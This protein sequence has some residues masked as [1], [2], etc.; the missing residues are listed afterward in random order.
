MFVTPTASLSRGDRERVANCLGL[1]PLSAQFCEYRKNEAL[2]PVPKSPDAPR[3]ILD[4]GPQQRV[5]SFKDLV[6]S[7]AG[8]LLPFPLNL[9][10]GPKEP[11]DSV[12]CEPA[13]FRSQVNDIAQTFWALE[14]VCRQVEISCLHLKNA[15]DELCVVLHFVRGKLIG[16][17]VDPFS[18]E[19]VTKF[20]VGVLTPLDLQARFGTQSCFRSFA[21]A[22]Q[23]NVGDT[24]RF[25][26]S[27]LSQ[28]DRSVL[29]APRNRQAQPAAENR[30][31]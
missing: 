8:S 12:V 23:G 15:G 24:A 21:N 28:A 17:Q 2:G 22:P 5:I 27:V 13:E 6:A 18:F 26:M 7:V 10:L 9:A 14:Q 4:H 30:L 19:L 20:T 11:D 1:W 29:Y 31:S 3:I 16:A 25:M